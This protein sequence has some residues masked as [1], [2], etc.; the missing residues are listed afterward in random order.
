MGLPSGF[1]SVGVSSACV[2]GLEPPLRTRM[3]I[4][5]FVFKC[6]FFRFWN[7]FGPILGGFGQPKRRQTSIFRRL[8]CDAFFECVSASISGRFWEAPNPEN[9]HGAS[10]GARFSQNRRFR[11]SSE[12]TLILAPFSEAKIEKNP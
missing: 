10:T 7:D 2:E 9:M 11:K 8:F 5:I 1:E 4:L 12:K 6:D 3:L